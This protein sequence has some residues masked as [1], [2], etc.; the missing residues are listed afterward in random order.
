MCAT[1]PKKDGESKDLHIHFEGGWEAH[2]KIQ[3]IIEIRDERGRRIK[4]TR[5]AVHDVDI[6]VISADDMTP[7]FLSCCLFWRSYARLYWN[8]I[9]QAQ[10]GQVPETPRALVNRHPEFSKLF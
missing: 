2:P 9:P 7:S 3:N 10:F 4:G 6:V 8:F 1:K 5:V